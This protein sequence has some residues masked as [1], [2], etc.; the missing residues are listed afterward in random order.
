MAVIDTAYKMDTI[1][2]TRVRDAASFGCKCATLPLNLLRTDRA[3]RGRSAGDSDDRFH[4]L[5]ARVGSCA[6]H[7]HHARTCPGARSLAHGQAPMIDLT[8][9]WTEPERLRAIQASTQRLL[10]KMMP[11]PGP[12][13]V[14]CLLDVVWPGLARKNI[15]PATSDRI[16][17]ALV[18]LSRLGQIEGQSGSYVLFGRLRTPRASRPSNLLVIKTRNKSGSG[19]ELAEEWKDALATKPHTFDRKD[20]FAIP[21]HFDPDDRDYEVLWSLCLP[22]VRESESDKI[23]FNEFRRVDD[24]RSLL[25]FQSNKT[26]ATLTED[27]AKATRVLKDTYKLLR[28]LHRTSA[29]AGSHHL[30]RTERTFGAEYDRYLRGYDFEGGGRWGPE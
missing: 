16:E 21:L 13:C 9:K 25:A 11:A 23:D 17:L 10:E 3:G 15:G 22:T 6:R 7:E 28:N 19:V 18:P 4:R 8:P 5:P 30:Q 14:W 1:T 2:T 27:H 29:A 20:S 26:T 24:L 12:A